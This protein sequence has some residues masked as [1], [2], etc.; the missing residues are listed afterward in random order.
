MAKIT[1]PLV[2]DRLARLG[3]DWFADVRRQD[4]AE[5]K[6]AKT[7]GRDGSDAG[8]GGFLDW[9][10]GDGDSDGGHHGGDGGE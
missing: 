6:R 5:K 2:D 10:F 7:S 9:L 4:A 8:E 3:R 1:P